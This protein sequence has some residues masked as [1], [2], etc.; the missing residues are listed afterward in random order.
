M[1]GP[2]SSGPAT[3]KVSIDLVEEASAEFI[4][5][6]EKWYSQERKIYDNS[7]ISGTTFDF[8]NEI[9]KTQKGLYVVTVGQRDNTYTNESV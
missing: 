2:M 8:D 3:S 4:E 6:A 9:Q 5:K 1:N 7:R